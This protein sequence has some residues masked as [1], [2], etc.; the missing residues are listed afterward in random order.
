MPD[1]YLGLGSN[2]R[3]QENLRLS[4]RELRKRFELRK[5]SS[6]Y[7]NQAVGF[8]GAEFLNAVAL[9]RTEMSAATVC[10]AL[11]EIHAISGRKRGTDAFVSRTLDI[12]LLLYG[13]ETIGKPSVPRA[14]V[15][16]YSFVLCP[17]AEIA[18][19]L[20]HPVTGQTMAEHWAAFD[21][22]SH[23]LIV[24]SLILLN[25]DL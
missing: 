14:D 6:V 2:L 5:V 20:A 1:V 24:D 16:R 4:I 7:R 11:E 9:V 10:N 25:G 18:P 21:A 15:L 19:D 17:L 23:P 3:P 8:A 12:D 13:Q 22:E